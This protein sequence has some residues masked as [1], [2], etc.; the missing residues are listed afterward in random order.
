MVLG[1]VCS[2]HPLS[3][4]LRYMALLSPSVA[5]VVPCPLPTAPKGTRVVALVLRGGG[6]KGPFCTTVLQRLG[7]RGAVVVGLSSL[8][9][10]AY[11]LQVY[12]YQLR[13]LSA[14]LRHNDEFVARG[15]VLLRVL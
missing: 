14:E 6:A 15:K 11:T 12:L 2:T 3:R 5:A 10:R 7:S 1:L 13:A 9:R 4:L 8:L